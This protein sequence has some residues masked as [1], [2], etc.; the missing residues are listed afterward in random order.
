M[1]GYVT[2]YLYKPK[3][4]FEKLM[5][6]ISGQE[7]LFTALHVKCGFMDSVFY[8]DKD[9]IRIA[10]PHAFKKVAGNPDYIQVFEVADDVDLT[11][12]V[13]NLPDNQV[14]HMNQIIRW[15]TRGAVD[16]PVCTDM[17]YHVLEIPKENK[18]DFL[19]EALITNLSKVRTTK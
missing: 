12:R 13:L 2:L 15:A 18:M 9:G 3:G 5:S 8:Y 11:G 1:T 14:T 16:M 4:F 7:Y 17:A 6:W 10:N 19:P